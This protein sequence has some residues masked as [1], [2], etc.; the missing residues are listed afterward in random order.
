MARRHQQLLTKK[1]EGVSG[2]RDRTESVSEVAQRTTRIAR[3]IARGDEL[4][5]EGNDRDALRA[6]R[7]AV[8]EDGK[9]IRA[10]MRI[11][12][13]AYALQDYHLSSGACRRVIQLRSEWSLP[14]SWLGRTLLCLGQW[15][16]AADAFQRGLQFGAEG[17]DR[18]LLMAAWRAM[19]RNDLI[20]CEIENWIRLM[21]DD[22][23]ATH[24]AIAVGL[25]KASRASAEFVR[26]T[27]DR[28]A[29][30]YEQTMLEKLGYQG[31]TVVRDVL[32]RM[33]GDARA[34]LQVVELGCGTGLCG[35]ELRAYAKG[36]TGVDLS[37]P[38]LEVAG[39]RGV[40][41]QLVEADIL[42]FFARDAGKC[43]L[44]VAIDVCNYLGDLGPFIFGSAHMV[45]DCGRCVFSVEQI[46]RD[47]NGD[48][49][50]SDYRLEVHGRFS[51]RASYIERLMR[52]AGW[53][54]VEMQQVHLRRELGVPVPMLLVEGV[55]H[56]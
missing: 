8:L 17:R 40:Y 15:S 2:S 25:R 54:I 55:R 46:S 13:A 31:P 39:K 35:V 33:F 38:M 22:P 11:A 47:S 50:G 51:H 36:L 43:D 20:R 9:N 37:A 18:E 24:Y 30:S 23:V 16:A 52:E 4:T 53:Q 5:A 21:P 41:D 1:R 7:L 42:D 14:Y 29:R 32:A 28:F 48:G 45:S 12:R 6:Y 34:D 19:G 49:A 10:M 3:H 27:F 56:R 44:V 26:T